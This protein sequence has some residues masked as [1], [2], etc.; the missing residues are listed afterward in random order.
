MISYR[1]A[2]EANIV[3]LF[4]NSFAVAGL[5][6]D[7]FT[8]SEPSSTTL[9][10]L[11][12]SVYLTSTGVLVFSLSP[13][14]S[15][16]VSRLSVVGKEQPILIGAELVLAPGLIPVIYCGPAK[17]SF[18]SD[19]S[20][21]WRSIITIWLLRNGFSLA[22][23]DNHQFW[24]SVR[25]LRHQQDSGQSSKENPTFLWPL[26]LCLSF[27]DA[28]NISSSPESGISSET[29]RE[30]ALWFAD[31]DNSGFVNMLTFA[32]QWF[33]SQ[34]ERGRRLASHRQQEKDAIA[35][36]TILTPASP[37]NSRA[38]TY[39]D[40]HGV[41]GVYPTPPDG[42][43]SQPGGGGVSMDTPI[44]LSHDIPLPNVDSKPFLMDLD[45]EKIIRH[46]AR[47]AM[48]LN[49]SS[50]LDDDIFGEIEEDDFVGNDVTDADFSF[51]DQPDEPGI[52]S[53]EADVKPSTDENDGPNEE[54]KTDMDYDMEGLVEA[55]KSTE[56]TEKADQAE[57][58][59]LVDTE[60]VDA[61]PLDVVASPGVHDGKDL[62]FL[63]PDEVQRRLFSMK[64]NN[65]TTYDP[66]HTTRKQSEY[67]PLMFN[68]HLRN[69][70]AKYS[71]SGTFG[72]EKL[73]L[74]NK[75]S[76]IS[77]AKLKIS[78]PKLTVL[79]NSNKNSGLNNEDQDVDDS[80][81]SLDDESSV[82]S[83]GEQF[84]PTRRKSLRSDHLSMKSSP[85]LGDMSQLGDEV[86]SDDM[87]SHSNLSSEFY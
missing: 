76:S 68:N 63:T 47:P 53:D 56:S 42:L 11:Q 61:E 5:K 75:V 62:G 33:Q 17:E 49:G 20:I 36:K 4:S 46:S 70:D 6:E 78:L 74:W 50:K 64:V 44:T 2:Q 38:I 48:Q 40:S 87:V 3:P 67:G 26:S 73:E 66:T 30:T 32:E 18:D 9:R 51:F 41:T 43:S 58:G 59:A 8:L 55:E 7:D 35:A 80:D 1:M 60:M 57:T 45:S 14:D 19:I 16:D 25:L 15:I 54:F 24:L 13:V 72:R 22:H 81:T 37:I 29:D 10:L 85:R 34:P 77:D 31:Q 86:N 83:T 12:S 23:Q 79:S 39:G 52:H 82:M 28:G 65:V 69:N 84:N 21:Q 71:S 27:S